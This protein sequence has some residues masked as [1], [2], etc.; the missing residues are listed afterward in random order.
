MYV[1]IRYKSIVLKTHWVVLIT[2]VFAFITLINTHRSI[3]LA[4]SVAVLLLITT[5]SIPLIRQIQFI[6]GIAAAL[7]ITSI[8]FSTSDRLDL[9]ELSTETS[10]VTS[11]TEF[12][13]VR[14]RGITDPQDD[15]TAS[16]RSY[17]WQQA[18]AE[19]NEQ[20]LVGVGIGRNFQFKTKWW[21][22]IHTSPH[23]YY[24]TSSFH[25]GYTALVLY[26]FFIMQVL[27]LLFSKLARTLSARTRTMLMTSM[28]VI[29]SAHT[30][31]IAYH[32]EFFSL[33]YIGLSIAVIMTAKKQQPEPILPL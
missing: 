25:G 18:I 7:F 4:S 11:L 9:G 21:D 2:I 10:N 5:G 33:L 20:P 27:W 22:V 29:F 13:E 23:N 3:W 19:T 17:L 30:M 16:W 6:V 14:L 12:L 15:P 32:H 1:A 28:I 26:V 8:L 24:I 31:F